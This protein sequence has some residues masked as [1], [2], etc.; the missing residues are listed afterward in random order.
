MFQS[1]GG[2]Q[3]TPLVLACGRPCLLQLVKRH[4]LTPHAY[5]DDIQIY[6]DCQ[7][8]DAYTAGLY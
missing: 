6:G 2:G 4:H 7:P 1:S 5:A 3:M 8:S